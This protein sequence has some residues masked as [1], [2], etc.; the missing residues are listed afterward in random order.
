MTKDRAQ[1]ISAR[2][3]DGDH[4]VLARLVKR[5]EDGLKVRKMDL[6]SVDRLEREG[7]V[8]WVDQRVYVVTAAGVAYMEATV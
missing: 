4:A 5:G 6:G 2:L 3:R 1:Q 7:L 8:A